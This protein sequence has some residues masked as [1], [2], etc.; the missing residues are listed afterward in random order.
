MPPRKNTPKA[1]AVLAA[2]Q[3]LTLESEPLP[4]DQVLRPPATDAETS[5]AGAKRGA[6]A[7]DSNTISK[8]DMAA[9]IASA[10]GLNESIVSL[11]LDAFFTATMK[12]LSIFALPKKGRAA[13]PAKPVTE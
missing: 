1:A 10:K 6:K 4:G 11:V 9:S 12:A 7:K 2:Q 5:K 13:E 8:N 3:T